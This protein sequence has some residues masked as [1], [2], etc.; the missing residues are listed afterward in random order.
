MKKEYADKTVYS[1]S[2]V[3]IKITADVG[4]RGGYFSALFLFAIV[5]NSENKGDNAGEHNDEFK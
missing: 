1:L 3:I 4:S 5:D 2:D